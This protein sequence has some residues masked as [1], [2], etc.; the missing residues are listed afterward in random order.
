MDAP[1]IRPGLIQVAFKEG[2][3]ADA[4]HRIIDQIFKEVG[5]TACGLNGFDLRFRVDDERFAQKFR[6]VEGVAHVGYLG[7]MK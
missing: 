6:N 1:N 2:I 5:C 3:N 7:G 4:I